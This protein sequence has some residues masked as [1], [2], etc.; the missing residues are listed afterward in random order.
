MSRVV[1]LNHVREG[2]KFPTSLVIAKCFQL[3]TYLG[4]ALAYAGVQVRHIG[5]QPAL[6]CGQRCVDFP[7]EP[8]AF[9]TSIYFSHRFI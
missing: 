1:H 5:L 4:T 7:A 6:L 8:V 2:M 9:S 3:C